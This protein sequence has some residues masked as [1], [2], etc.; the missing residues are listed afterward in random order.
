MRRNKF[1][2][3]YSVSRELLNEDTFNFFKLSTLYAVKGELMYENITLD[4]L[5]F[6]EIQSEDPLSEW[7]EYYVLVELPEEIEVPEE[8]AKEFNKK[9]NQ[10]SEEAIG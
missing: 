1:S 4:N 5:T 3:T 2:N 6:T 8:M 10:I 9:F 7:V